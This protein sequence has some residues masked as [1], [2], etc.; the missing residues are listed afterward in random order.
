MAEH[1][2]FLACNSRQLLLVPWYVFLLGP[3][4]R[5]PPLA[6]YLPLCSWRQQGCFPLH[7]LE[8]LFS[9]CRGCGCPEVGQGVQRAAAPTA[10]VQPRLL[11]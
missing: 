6:R 1:T 9:P 4:Q 5:S 3:L 8:V 11:W 7:F 2:G 10:E